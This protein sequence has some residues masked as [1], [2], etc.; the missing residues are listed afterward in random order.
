MGCCRRTKLFRFNEPTKEW[1]E[2]G[3]G[4]VRFLRH[5]ESNK[6]NVSPSL[7]CTAHHIARACTHST[8]T[9]TAATK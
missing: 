1:K 8:K 4:D 7:T 5:K 2:R 6:V 3:T 9:P